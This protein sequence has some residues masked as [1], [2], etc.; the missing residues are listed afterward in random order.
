[1]PGASRSTNRGAA[2]GLA[3]ALGLIA[4]AVAVPPAFGWSVHVRSFPP[5]HASWNPRV[6]VGTVPAI[7]LAVLVSRQAVSMAESL[8]WRQLLVASYAGGLAWMLSLALVDGQRGLGHIL[9]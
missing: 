2:I 8:G 5:L 3:V 4:L 9:G 6:G 7:L 1:M